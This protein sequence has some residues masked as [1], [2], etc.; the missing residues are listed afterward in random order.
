[1]TFLNVTLY[2]ADPDDSQD[3]DGPLLVNADSIRY[4]WRTPDY[5]TR[6][7]FREGGTLD[8][9]ESMSDVME[10]LSLRGDENV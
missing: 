6:I 5:V 8:I 7:Y 3:T 4:I 1:M 2:R 10:A 9:D